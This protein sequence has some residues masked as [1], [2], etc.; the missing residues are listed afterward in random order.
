ML[1]RPAVTLAVELYTP[2]R[3]REFDEA[4]AETIRDPDAEILAGYPQ[5]VMAGAMPGRKLSEP[6][7]EALVLYLL[8]LSGEAKL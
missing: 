5:G 6:E 2:E 8:S 1:L 7:V 3:E 4:E